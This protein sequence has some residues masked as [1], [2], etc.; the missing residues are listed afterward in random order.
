VIRRTGPDTLT[1][2]T[3]F[4]SASRIAAPIH[5]AHN[6]FFIVDGESSCLDLQQILSK[7]SNIPNGLRSSRREA[8]SFEN[9]ILQ[10]KAMKVCEHSLS[11]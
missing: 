4:P 11:E 7:P 5:L 1:P 3:T 9:L 2:P 6:S 8:N 10:G